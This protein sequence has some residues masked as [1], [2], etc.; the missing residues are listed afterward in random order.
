MSDTN[1]IAA[2]FIR[3]WVKD[4]PGAT[5][6]APMFEGYYPNNVDKKNSSC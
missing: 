3:Q 2:E 6:L 5:D 1:K 4:N